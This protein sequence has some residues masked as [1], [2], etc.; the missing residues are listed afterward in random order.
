LFRPLGK[1][2]PVPFWEC[3][4][5][6]TDR[7]GAS[8]NSI[9]FWRNMITYLSVNGFLPFVGEMRGIKNKERGDA[10]AFGGRRFMNYTQQSIESQL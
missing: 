6:R 9:L 8:K 7:K 4:K 10:L 1:K 2:E 3:L 5:N